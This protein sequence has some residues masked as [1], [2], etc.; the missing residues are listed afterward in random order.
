[1][2]QWKNFSAYTEFFN[3]SSCMIVTVGGVAGL[4]DK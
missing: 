2:P 4:M 1:M 3:A